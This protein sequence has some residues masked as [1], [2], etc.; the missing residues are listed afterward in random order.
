MSEELRISL[1][2][3]DFIKLCQTGFVHIIIP[4]SKSQLDILIN[5]DIVSLNHTF[6]TRHKTFEVRE[7]K[8]ILQDIGYGKIFKHLNNSTIY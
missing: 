4:I 1:S 2:E 3:D 7:V 6:R 5:G 8:I